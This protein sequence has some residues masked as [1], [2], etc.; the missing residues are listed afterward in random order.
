MISATASKVSVRLNANALFRRSYD[1]GSVMNLLQGLRLRRRP[2]CLCRLGSVLRGVAC[3][4][5]VCDGE[6]VSLGE[7]R[8]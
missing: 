4:T 8:L 5:G 6:V 1:V 3:V 2:H 7:W